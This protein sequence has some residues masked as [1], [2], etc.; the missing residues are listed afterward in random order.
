M[1]TTAGAVARYCVGDV[2][3]ERGGRPPGVRRF[4]RERNRRRDPV[5]HR[6]R[7]HLIAERS[8]RPVA[9]HDRCTALPALHLTPHVLDECV[10]SGLD[11][12]DLC[13]GPVT[14]GSDDPELEIPDSFATPDCI[15]LRPVLGG[16]AFDRCSRLL[17][18]EPERWPR[19]GGSPASGSLSASQAAL[20]RRLKASSA[21]RATAMFSCDIPPVSTRGLPC[22]NGDRRA[23]P[24]RREGRRLPAALRD[25]RTPGARVARGAAGRR[26]LRRPAGEVAGAIV[27]A[28]QKRPAPWSN[29]APRPVPAQCRCHAPTGVAQFDIGDV[30]AHHLVGVRLEPE[31]PVQRQRR[32]V[33]RGGP[34]PRRPTSRKRQRVLDKRP[35]DS[36]SHAIRPDDQAADT[37]LVVP[38]KANEAADRPV[39]VLGNPQALCPQIINRVVLRRQ[40]LHADERRLNRIASPLKAQQDLAIAVKL[41]TPDD[42]THTVMSVA[43][44]T[45]AGP[46]SQAARSVESTV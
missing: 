1:D 15:G 36:M 39:L 41:R 27:E 9:E 6:G 17:A 13:K 8:D 20:S 28:E 14:Q 11:E 16:N 26:Q 37:Q 34:D 2:A 44:A 10:V 25:G 46:A 38:L 35:A 33:G 43:A 22:G 23:E 18:L 24:L 30:V 32:R 19:R 45:T 4:R 29:T 42:H 5:L 40:R 7:D 3:G 21:L 31:R 12:F